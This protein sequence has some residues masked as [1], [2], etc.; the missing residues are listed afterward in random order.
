MYIAP[1]HKGHTKESQEINVFFFF[2]S[3]GKASPSSDIATDG[4][5]QIALQ[6]RWKQEESNGG[7]LKAR[8]IKQLKVG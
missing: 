7:H 4:Q 2:F 3:I 8:A 5:Y 1:Q 6:D